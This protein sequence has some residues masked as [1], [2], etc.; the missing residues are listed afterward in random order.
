MD[1]ERW[2]L[3]RLIPTSGVNGAEEQERRATS[4]LLAVMHSVREFCR[5][6]T[7]PLGAPVGVAAAYIEVPFVLHGKRLYPDGLIEIRR[8]NRTWTALV[9]VRTGANPLGAPQVEDYLDI[10]RERGFDAVITISN[11]IAPISGHHPTRVEGRKPRKVAL[12][13]WTWSHVL[14]EAVAQ[15]AHRGVADAEQAWILGELIRYLEH[16]KSGALE[17]DDMGPSWA[18]VRET[19]AEGTLHPACEDAVD[20][21]RHFEAL[22]RF[23]ALRLGR[24]LGDDATPLLTRRELA[25]PNGRVHAL[26]ASLRRDGT[27]SGAI[28]V[29]SAVGPLAVTVDLKAATV[30]CHV[31]LD[32]PKTGGA[33]TRVRWLLGQLDGAD[34]GIRVESFL[35]R[36]RGVAAAEPLSV[37][38]AQPLLLSPDHTRDLRA[39]R[40]VLRAPMG[41]GRRRGPDAFIDS[42]IRAVDH[43]YGA[44][45][46]QLKA[47][48][49]PVLRESPPVEPVAVA[50]TAL[51]S[52]DGPVDE[53]HP[54]RVMLNFERG[55]RR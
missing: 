5:A 13:H 28:R 43:F 48:S 22:V 54:P 40:L 4:A 21:A 10:A 23:V 38:R 35:R 11:E 46:Q 7:R 49:P 32:A 2:N 12:Y 31:D 15:K 6:L 36:G 55:S 30:T 20:V 16:P 47:W 45:V 50:A 52:Q 34:G 29:P 18:P 3:A 51:S 19:L 8:G 41:T 42:V 44:V 26:A 24:R 33:A 1:R 17:F 39:F 27:M 14:A 25:D 9:E 37:V 53:R